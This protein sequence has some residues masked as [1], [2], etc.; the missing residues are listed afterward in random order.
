MTINYTVFMTFM[1]LAFV[2]MVVAWFRTIG[3]FRRNRQPEQDTFNPF[4]GPRLW[5]RFFTA[6]S[7]GPD[8]EAERRSIT[9]T[10]IN[11]FVCFLL[12]VVVYVVFPFMPA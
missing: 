7:L 5:I 10:Y 2:L 6:H 12:V 11:A 9:K 1:S 8:P 3:F 4:N